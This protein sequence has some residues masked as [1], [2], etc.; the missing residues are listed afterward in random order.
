MK[1]TADPGLGPRVDGRLSKRRVYDQ[2][3]AGSG[4]MESVFVTFTV[5]IQRNAPESR[6]DLA[7]SR[8]C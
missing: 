5:E 8:P 7:I 6:D 2:N 1:S 3:Q 4:A